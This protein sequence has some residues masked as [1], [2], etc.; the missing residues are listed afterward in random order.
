MPR[1][2]QYDEK[3]IEIIK[4]LESKNAIVVATADGDKVAA[5]TVYFIL[6]ES[7]I[8]F[9]TSKAYSKYKQI[10]KKPNVALCVDN[11]QIE[12][13]AYVK[14]H[15]CLEQNKSI[16][17]CYLEKCPEKEN[18]RRYI[19]HKNTVF[20]E[21]KISKIATWRDG[22]REYINPTEKSAYRVG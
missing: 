12:G 3:Y 6:H 22:G 10:I 13:I 14:G 7:S 1:Q 16:L 11:I 21:V 15:P 20:I 9:L 8:Y 18:N 17:D 19:K 2:L 4:F 5:R